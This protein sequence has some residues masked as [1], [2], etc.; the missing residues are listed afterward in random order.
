MKKEEIRKIVYNCIEDTRPMIYD[1]IELQDH[2]NLVEDLG[3]ESV[4][5]I[6]LIA[7]I[8]EKFEAHC[9]MNLQ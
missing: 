7:L 1:D 9:K 5:T 3:F 2:L 8:E 6:Q 4:S